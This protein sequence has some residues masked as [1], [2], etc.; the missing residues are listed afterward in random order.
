MRVEAPPLAIA[1]TVLFCCCAGAPESAQRAD[2]ADGASHSSSTSSR[3][4]SVSDAAVS[5]GRTSAAAIAPLAQASAESRSVTTRDEDG[6]WIGRA[7]L[8]RRLTSGRDWEELLSDARRPHGP[9]NIADQDSRHDVFTLAAALVCVRIGEYC[10]KAEQG[11]VDAMG[12]ESAARWL[13]VGRN[14]GAYVIAADLLD[15]REGG[16]GGTRGASV[17]RWL[18][19]FMTKTLPDNNTGVPRQLIPF[20]TGANASA[21]EGFVYT[22]LAAY[23][24][25]ERALGR[26]WDAFRTF[27]CDPA[28]PDR[29]GIDLSR[30]VADG[31]AHDALRPCAINP[32]GSAKVIATGAAGVSA[33]ALRLDGAIIAD[34]RRGG[35]FGLRPTFTAY[36][37]VGLEGVVPAA[38]IL[39]R[40]GYPAF[41][42]A[43]R[44]L[45]RAHEYLWYLRTMTGDER[46]FDGSRAREI[47]HLVNVV[48]GVSFPITQTIGAG[49]TV[50]YTGW[51]HPR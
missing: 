42:V 40:A 31:W 30:P 43:D 32:A 25:D 15:L 37:W 6:I 2:G 19:S 46:W 9:A 3:G 16:A 10:E 34:M 12:T 44:A 22:A 27:V 45:L 5:E 11:I 28:A 26:A 7:D 39:E 17:E 8:M 50:G 20:E 14:L 35:V 47:V 21:Q 29:E 51:T 36:P 48:Y 18:Q 4:A 24:G 1:L 38:V 49:R 23:L 13:A 41:E 33:R